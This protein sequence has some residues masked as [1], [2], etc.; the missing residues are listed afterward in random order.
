MQG[1]NSLILLL[2]MFGVFYFLMIRPQVKKQKEHQAM[3]AAIKKGDV[4]ITR[5]GIIGTVT[6]INDNELVLELQEKVRVRVLRSFVEGKHVAAGQAAGAAAEAEATRG[7]ARAEADA[8]LAKARTDA[9]GLVERRTRMAEDK[10]AAAERG[11]VAEVRARAAQAA[12]AAAARIIAERNDAEAD[13]AL[14][15]RTIAGLT[16]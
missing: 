10:I 3:L 1:P 14:V 2:I 13:R 6:G 9:E 12:A 15:D 5:G 7:R 11:A 8:I 4:V 16:H